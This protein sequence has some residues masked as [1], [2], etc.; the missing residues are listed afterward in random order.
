MPTFI[1]LTPGFPADE[2][3][4]TC[5]PAFQQFAQSVKKLYPQYQLTVITFQYPFVAH[6]YLWNGI[7]VIALGGS[8][9]PR[10]QRFLT[11]CRA[12]KVLKRLKKE[13]KIIGLLS[14]WLTECALVG[15]IFAKFHR[16]KHYMWLIGQD[17]KKNNQY[18]KRIKP[19]GREIIAMSDF[20]KEE[21]FKNHGELPFMIAEN[22]IVESNFP[23][24]N[25]GERPVDIL[26]VG[27][28]TALKNYSLFIELV[29]E[30]KK[31]FPNINA[32]LIG[33]GEEEPRLKKKVAELQL[34]KNIRFEGLR[35][36]SE[37]F[38]RMNQSKVFLHTSHY[39]GNSTVLMEALYSGCYT[40]STRPLS[41]AKVEHLY[42]ADNREVLLRALREHLEK[43]NVTYSRVI[44]NTMDNTVQKILNLFTREH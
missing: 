22:G 27:S 32:S 14:L 44:F 2:S 12:Y 43:K 19:K 3:D 24:F 10:L 41:N 35:S 25:T 34:E 31:D 38:E 21:Y 29:Q 39:E 16:L 17:A 1:I 5:L 37:V 9:R 30:L 15:K 13:E 33:A 20:L 11:W 18:I 36:H 7:R 28:L 26:G 6:E 40:F 42:I 4:T 8:N 23:E